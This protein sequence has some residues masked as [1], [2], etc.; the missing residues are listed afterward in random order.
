M[1]F[2]LPREFIVWMKTGLSVFLLACVYLL[3]I[4]TIVVAAVC[5]IVRGFL[6]YNRPQP[7]ICPATGHPAELRIGA[8]RAAIARLFGEKEFQILSCSEAR[9]LRECNRACISQIE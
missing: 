6:R 5:I 4:A 9:P 1:I 7:V 8:L 3:S 2:D